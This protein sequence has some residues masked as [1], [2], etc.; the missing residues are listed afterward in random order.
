MVKRY[1][2]P[3]LPDGLPAGSLIEADDSAPDGM[4]GRPL[5]WMTDEL[6]QD[7]GEEWIRLRAEHERTG[8]YPLM[9]EVS[10]DRDD[11]WHE[12]WHS[13]ELEDVFDQLDLAEEFRDLWDTVREDRHPADEDGDRNSWLPSGPWPGT[14]KPGCC[15]NDPQAMASGMARHLQEEPDWRGRQRRWRLGLVPADRGA[16]A[17]T[18]AGWSGPC[19]HTN[20]IEQLS[21]VLRSWEDR[22]G[23][24]VVALGTDTLTLSIA[25]P[26]HDLEHA[27]AIT[28]EHFAFCPDTLW[29][30]HSHSVDEYAETLI[31][32]NTWTFWWD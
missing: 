1:V 27:R 5:L 14:A 31:D 23:A 30:G 4:T 20:H 10:W 24:R 32:M 29:Q 16:D 2:F 21:I 13:P 3:P 22:F 11:Y 26:P 6:V 19:N 9:L 17:L 12:Y 8:L 18:L 25:D 28:L 15:G 7:A